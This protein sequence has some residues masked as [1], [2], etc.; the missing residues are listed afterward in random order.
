M[1]EQT[2][3]ERSE[4]K[5]EAPKQD[6]RSAALADMINVAASL[7]AIQ[8]A[9]AIEAMK[10]PDKRL[11]DASPEGGAKPYTLRDDG[12]GTFTKIN[13]FGDEVNESGELTARG[14]E[15]AAARAQS[16]VR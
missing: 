15:S 16:G 11:D 3:D 7:K 5:A 4:A 2:K 12:D 14:R 8:D 1:A 9:A 13:A 6:S 10:L